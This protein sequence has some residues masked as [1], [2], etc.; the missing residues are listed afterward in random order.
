MSIQQRKSADWM[1]QLD[2]RIL[3]KI[4][5]DGWTTPGMLAKNSKFPEYEGVIS[6]RCDRLHYVGFIE[7]F[8]GKMYDLTV[9]GRLYLQGEIDA[10][11][12]PYPKA[13]A[14]HKKWSFPPGWQPG[15]LRFRL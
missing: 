9:E 3:E 13:S 12:Q 4:E 7:P 6:D 5:T 14:V 10:K 2:E 8:H 15:P 11:H 1:I